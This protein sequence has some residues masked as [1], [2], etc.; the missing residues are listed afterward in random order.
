MNTIRQVAAKLNKSEQYIRRCIR[1]GK[2][3]ST[4]VQIKEGSK[5][6]R[7]EISD[8]ALEMFANRSSNRSSREDGRNKYV[9]YF[10]NEEF[11][12]VVELLIANDLAEVAELIARA[13]PSKNAS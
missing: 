3:E 7:H 11:E 10:N 1:E 9:A 2:I 5:I 12:S 6:K 8:E 13:N 4:L